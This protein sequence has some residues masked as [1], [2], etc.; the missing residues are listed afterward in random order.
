MK[1]NLSLAE[2]I[3]AHFYRRRK[4]EAE[5]KRSRFQQ[6]RIIS[7]GNITTGGTGKTPATAWVVRRLQ[8]EGQRVAVVGRGYGG[9]LSAQ[10]AVVSDGKTILISAAQAGDEA[11][12]HARSLP[13]VPVIIG[14]DR[15]AAVQMAIEK[16]APQVIVLDD[17]FQYWS[18]HRDFDLVLLNAR[19]PFGNGK[20]LPVGR[21]REP[22]GELAR[23]S[24]ILLTRAD[25]ATPAQL[26]QTQEQI[27][28]FSSAPIFVSNHAPQ[29]LRSE[30]ERVEQALESLHGQHV[31][32]LAAL[33]N[34]EPFFQLLKEQGA[35]VVETL[36]RRDHHRWQEKEVHEFAAKAQ[37]KGAGWLVTTEKDAVKIAP[38][39]CAPLP[40]FSLQIALQIENDAGLWELVRSRI[41]SDYS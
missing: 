8:N 36:G 34:N 16:F 33:A 39:W 31:A 20:L 14:R 9:E 30:T 37:K 19:L 29:T 3:Y 23:A 38:E 26:Q 21:L 10:G 11:L 24:A 27:R 18:L 41:A 5:S 35:E 28:R 13:G 22:Q 40:L 1:K 15:V 12:F 25:G 4:S 17:G 6:V 7:V 32:G 2:A